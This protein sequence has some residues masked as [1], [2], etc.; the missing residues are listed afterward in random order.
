MIIFNTR[1]K[2]ITS[3]LI[4]ASFC[5][6][7]WRFTFGVWLWFRFTFGWT[8]VLGNWMWN[9]IN[10]WCL[11]R[12]KRLYSLDWKTIIFWRNSFVNMITYY[13]TRL[14]YCSTPRVSILL[15]YKLSKLLCNYDIF[16]VTN[17]IWNINLNNILLHV[18]WENIISVYYSRILFDLII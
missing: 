18:F 13:F 3:I 1:L 14:F 8:R 5:V 15:V 11:H 17:Y 4:I 2:G 7:W 6:G 9:R 12:R 10:T 16:I